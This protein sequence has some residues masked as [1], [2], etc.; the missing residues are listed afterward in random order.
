VEDNSV[1]LILPVHNQEEIIES[2][3]Y[4]MMTNASENV[5]ELIII[6]DGCTDNSESIIKKTLENKPEKL[7]TKIFY[8]N[9]VWEIICCNM[10][11]KE[12]KCRYSLNI[13][14]D[15]LI[16]ELDFDK[17]ML[18]P[19]KI[20]PNLLGV[21]ARNAQDETIVNGKLQYL[22]VAGK[23]VNT[24]RDLFCIRDVIVRGPILL[25]NEKLASLGYLDEIYVPQDLEEKD[26]CFRAYRKGMV[27]GFYGMDYYSPIAWGGTR[28]NPS[29]HHIWQASH[30]K[31]EIIL[32][33]R[34]KDLLMATKHDEEI[35]IDD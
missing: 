16:Q 8:A 19:F 7:E 18:K 24:P 29:K 27:V 28:K 33:E 15:M 32:M 21:T 13:Q 6:V 2:I 17:R 10:G 14:D 30:D 25:D 23:D 3:L 34:H 20:I 4:G 1:S 22:N 12:S 31:N 35:L 26:L 11:F 5:K 9:D